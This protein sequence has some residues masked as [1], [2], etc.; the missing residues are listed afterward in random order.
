M[1]VIQLIVV[2][3]QDQE[4]TFGFLQ[5]RQHPDG[6]LLPVLGVMSVTSEWSQRTAMVTFALEPSRGRVIAAKY[7]SALVIAVVAAGRRPT[8]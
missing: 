1:L 6:I 2:L 8:S 4:A 3:G 7:V 5:R